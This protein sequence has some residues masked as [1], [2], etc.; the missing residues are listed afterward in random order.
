NFKGD[1]AGKDLVTLADYAA[2][3]INNEIRRVP[4][5]GKVQFFGAEAAMRVWIDPQKLLGYG[6]SVANVN[7]AIAAQNVQVPAG[8][9]GSPPG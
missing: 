7:E 5:V 3:R 2:R 9:F 8:S 1:D 6:L 4:G